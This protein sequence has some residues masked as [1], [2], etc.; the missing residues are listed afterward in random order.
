MQEEIFLK[1]LEMGVLPQILLRYM[2]KTL[3][4]YEK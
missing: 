4:N 3:T 1:V 2:A